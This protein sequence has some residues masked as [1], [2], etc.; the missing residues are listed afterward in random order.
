MSRLETA[1]RPLLTPMILGQTVTLDES[2]QLVLAR[3]AVKAAVV[4]EQLNR[5]DA[6]FPQLDRYAV[7]IG[8]LTDRTQ[9]FLAAAERQAEHDT[10]WAGIMMKLDYGRPLEEW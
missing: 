8:P 5:L 1:A 3:W 10:F 7:R 2:Q 4:A 6:V 9:V